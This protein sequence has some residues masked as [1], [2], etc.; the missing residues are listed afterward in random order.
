VKIVRKR[1]FAVERAFKEGGE[2]N[3]YG[4]MRMEEAFSS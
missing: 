3:A 2:R 4:L 1:A